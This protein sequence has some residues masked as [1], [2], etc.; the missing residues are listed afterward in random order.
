MVKDSLEHHGEE[1]NRM[2][3]SSQLTIRFI[4][5]RIIVVVYKVALAMEKTYT[6]E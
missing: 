6:S 4:P 2:I 3:H 1:V 5:K